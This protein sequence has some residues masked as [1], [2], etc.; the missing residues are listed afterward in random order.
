MA[1]LGNVATGGKVPFFSERG[2]KIIMIGGALVGAYVL[3]KALSGFI[4]NES[5]RAENQSAS[6]E[7]DKLN[8]NP[9]TKQKI[10]N[11]QAEQLANKIFTAMD[12]YQTDEETIYNAFYQLKNN[13]DFLAVSKAYGTRTISSGQWNFVRDFKGTLTQCLND[14]LDS[15]ERYKVNK[16]LKAKNIRFRI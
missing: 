7:L 8:N 3:Y 14:E 5:G 15:G 1:N 11:Y 9:S 2:F 16:I 13:A 12:G 4:A 10:S 6:D